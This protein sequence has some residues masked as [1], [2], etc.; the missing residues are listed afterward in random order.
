MADRGL[1]H[2]GQFKSSVEA[3]TARL[4]RTSTRRD[5]EAD[6]AEA[7]LLRAQ[8]VRLV[9]ENIRHDE[10]RRVLLE[11]AALYQRLAHRSEDLH[12]AH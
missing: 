1:S 12:P 11:I 7:Y 10:S 5:I 2:T 4:D 3:D 6:S 9:A 8:E